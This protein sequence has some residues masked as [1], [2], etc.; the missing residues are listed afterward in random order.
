[1]RLTRIDVYQAALPYADGTY[2]WGRGHVLG[3]AVSTVVALTTDKGLRGYGEACPIDGAYL[4]AHAGGI[5]PAIALG[6]PLYRVV[7]DKSAAEAETLLKTYRQTG[8]RQFQIKVG[9]D[10][11]ADVDRSE[12][13]AALLTREETAFADANRG[14]TQHDAVQLFRAVRDTAV[15]IEQPCFGYE[16]CLHVRRHCDLP[17]KLDEVICEG[18]MARRIIADQAC[19]VACL[20][21]SNLGGLTKARQVRDLFC[22]VGFSVVSEDTWGGQI[23]TAAVAHFAASTPPELI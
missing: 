12:L 16:E 6:V 9:K 18:A 17:M 20:K 8:Y 2:Q 1:M 22:E 3:T 10:W 23:T 5:P 14:W 19:E 21:L 15:M 4:P 11:R 13:A 7:P